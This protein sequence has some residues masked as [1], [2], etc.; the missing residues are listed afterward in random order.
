MDTQN[1]AQDSQSVKAPSVCD[2][3]QDTL[4]VVDELPDELP[5]LPEELLWLA[6]LI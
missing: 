1:E 5:I 4:V 2:S 6:G 3:I